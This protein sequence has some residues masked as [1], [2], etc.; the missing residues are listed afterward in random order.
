MIVA[1]CADGI[2]A[3]EPAASFDAAAPASGPGQGAPHALSAE[4][5]AAASQQPAATDSE[6]LPED[7]CSVA[8]FLPDAPRPGRVM[9]AATIGAEGG[10]VRL[11]DFE[12]VVP[13]GALS[14][15]THFSIALPPPGP[16]ADRAL[17]EFKPHNVTFA[18]P[19][20]IR[21]PRA[22][23]ES[24]PG[25]PIAWWQQSTKSWIDQQTTELDDGRIEASVDHFSY[26][27]TRLRGVTIAGG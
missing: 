23:T 1:S 12:I 26:Y 8:R 22:T 4:P 21:L 9:A 15:P 13:A 24:A 18:Q 16:A 14:T 20:M 3:P 7:L 17:A 6:P 10:S 25:A 2:V 5:C 11:G 19:V 27:A